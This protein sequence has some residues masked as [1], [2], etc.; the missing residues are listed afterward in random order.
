MRTSATIFASAV[1]LAL[2]ACS[3]SSSS[4][5]AGDG[6]A[7]SMAGTYSLDLQFDTDGSVS[8]TGQGANGV[9][10]TLN[11]D[12]TATVAGAPSGMTSGGSGGET[13][14]AAAPCQW[15]PFPT[16][17][18]CDGARV[19]CTLTSS[20]AT[21]G[22]PD[23]LSGSCVAALFFLTLDAQNGVTGGASAAGFCD[24]V[25]TGTRTP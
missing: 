11:A 3:S 17:T 16:S 1:G 15:A 20:L 23:S 2:A 6:G 10:L 25:L 7:C 22:C 13:V 19:V 12:G 5:S 21:G 18:T 14:S 4:S 24:W 8:C 9:V